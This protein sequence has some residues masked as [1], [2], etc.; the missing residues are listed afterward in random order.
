MVA[1]SREADRTIPLFGREELYEQ[2]STR[3]SRARGGA[4]AAIVLVGEGGVGKSTLLARIGEDAAATGF[5]VLAARALPSDLPRPFQVIQDLVRRP[6]GA[7]RT[8]TDGGEA[9]SGT[10]PMF[11]VPFDETPAAGSTDSV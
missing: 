5:T 9:R 7:N 8:G 1:A 11:L 3:L 4:A 2:L 6:A 10:L